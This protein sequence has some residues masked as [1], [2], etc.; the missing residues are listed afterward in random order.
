MNQ[1]KILISGLSDRIHKATMD[2]KPEVAAALNEYRE[3]SEPWFARIEEESQQWRMSSVCRELT[4]KLHAAE[5]QSEIYRQETLRWSDAVKRLETQLAVAKSDLEF[6]RDLYAH[7][8]QQ[9]E[10]ARKDSK[11]ARGAIREAWLELTQGG[12]DGYAN[13][14]TILAP[15]AEREQPHHCGQDSKGEN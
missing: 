15:L 4:A 14:E 10:A 7:Q 5:A 12:H 3:F 8:T 2:G 11:E 1:I 6:R 13:A 9:L